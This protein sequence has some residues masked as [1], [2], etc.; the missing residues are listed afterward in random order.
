MTSDSSSPATNPSSSFVIPIT[1]KLMKTNYWLWRGQFLPAVRVTHL[2]DVILGVDRMPVK[3]IA[4]KSGN[5][6]TQAPNPK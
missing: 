3:T 6:V 1:E 4:P 5:S 2:E